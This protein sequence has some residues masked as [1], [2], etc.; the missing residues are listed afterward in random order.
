MVKSLS[1]IYLQFFPSFYIL[2]YSGL[3]INFFFSQEQFFSWVQNFRTKLGLKRSRKCI[4][5]DNG[6]KVE[7]ANLLLSYFF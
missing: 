4:Y 3:E 5:Y 1:C 7:G 2:S 6:P